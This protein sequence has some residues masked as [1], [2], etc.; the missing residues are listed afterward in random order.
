MVKWLGEQLQSFVQA[1]PEGHAGREAAVQ[2]VRREREEAGEHCV[3][4]LLRVPFSLHNALRQHP[5][6]GLLVV[7]AQRAH[8]LHAHPRLRWRSR[9][10]TCSSAAF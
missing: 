6:P 5:H 1:G 10:H 2:E 7:P 3:R 9:G 8:H 4:A